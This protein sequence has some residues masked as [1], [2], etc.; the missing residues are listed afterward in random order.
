[1]QCGDP[2]EEIRIVEE[3]SEVIDGLHF[4]ELVG[5]DAEGVGSHAMHGRV[6]ARQRPQQHSRIVGDL[7]IAKDR[8]EHVA[9][10]LR[11][12]SAATHQMRGGHASPMHER[13][14]V[15][16]RPLA[17]ASSW[18]QTE[19]FQP[20]A[21]DAF[22]PATHETS[23]CRKRSVAQ[24]R[25]AVRRI[26]QAQTIPLRTKRCERSFMQKLAYVFEEDSPLPYGVNSV[27]RQLRLRQKAH[28][29]SGAKHGGM[30][31]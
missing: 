24:D 19:G 23:L 28:A 11:S 18:F 12:A 9:T 27:P 26:H 4:D 3:R 25:F 2:A 17:V 29:V 30:A 22:L 15:R 13:G 10:D 8:R 31:V 16:S 14:V 21:I 1:M 20:C 6:F 5:G 7:Q